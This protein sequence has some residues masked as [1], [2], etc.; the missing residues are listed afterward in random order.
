M[1]DL[2]PWLIAL[3]LALPFG[4]LYW[5]DRRCPAPT[6]PKERP[7]LLTYCAWCVHRD[8]DDCTHPNS[9]VYGQGYSP[10]CIRRVRCDV[11]DAKP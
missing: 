9:L 11:R 3:V 6:K 10:V 5:A 7:V 8:A 1:P 4:F 2:V